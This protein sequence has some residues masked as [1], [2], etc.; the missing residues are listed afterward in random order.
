MSN[1]QEEPKYLLAN[2]GAEVDRLTKQH[3]WLQKC[4]DGQIVFGPVDLGKPDLRVLDVGCADGILLRDLRKGVAPSAELVG[5]DV[6]PSFLPPNDPGPPAIRY[7]VHDICDPVPA[8]MANTFDFTHVRFVMAGA[9]KSGIA[10]AVRN[11]VGS[12]APG[13]WL[14]IQE[15]DLSPNTPGCTPALE[16]MKSVLRSLFEK[17]GADPLFAKNLAKMLE[18]AGLQNVAVKKVKYWV[19]KGMGENQADVEASIASVKLTIPAILGGAASTFALF[20]FLVNHF[21]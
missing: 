12:V 11:L 15:M 2:V 13:G 16:D 4:L 8:N 18:D 10:E 17:T 9:S 14:Q 1:K 6:T 20:R 7:A 19:G 5:L 3:A 21:E